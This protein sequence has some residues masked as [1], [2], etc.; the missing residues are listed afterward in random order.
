MFKYLQKIGKAF[1]LPIGLLPDAGLLLGIGGEFTAE[2]TVK[3]YPIL[4]NQVL[5]LI[6]G[7]KAILYKNE[8][9]NMMGLED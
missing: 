3:A 2:A 7:A 5:R 4:Q 6:Y 1:M 8:I 9:S